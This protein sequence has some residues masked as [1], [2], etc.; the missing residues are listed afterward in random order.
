MDFNKLKERI[1]GSKDES[2]KKQFEQDNLMDEFMDKLKE[3][4]YHKSTDIA[5][6]LDISEKIDYL[7]D[8]PNNPEKF[9]NLEAPFWYRRI[10]E[11]T[12]QAII[13]ELNKNISGKTLNIGS[14]S[15]PYIDS[16]N[17][18]ISFEMLNWNPSK[19]KIQADALALP[20]KEDSFDSIIAVFVVNYIKDLNTF[21]KEIKRVLKKNS[22]L[23]LVQGKS[24]NP[25][26][27]LAENKLFS[28][29]KF[30]GLLRN[31]GFSVRKIEKNNLIFLRCKKVS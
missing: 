13:E 27:Q 20:F 7:K 4:N 14:G 2:L 5:S 16:I 19:N 21:I 8:W 24:I 26:H 31:N 11:N 1:F 25:L 15:F 10:D 9:W 3:V 22:N 17:L 23:F 28:I 18:D 6:L 30:A 29:A 12:K